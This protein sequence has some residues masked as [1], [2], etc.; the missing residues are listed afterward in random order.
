M[1]PRRQVPESASIIPFII[2][3]MVVLPVP[4]APIRATRSPR[5]ISKLMSSNKWLLPKLFDR[6]E[7]VRT[8]LP[9]TTEGS[10]SIR[11]P[12]D[13]AKGLSITSILDRSFSRLSAR[14]M[15]FSRLNCFNLSITCCWCL[16]SR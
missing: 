6:W 5:L 11:M 12:E 2:F 16:I 9:L 15:D 14:F 10:K 3:R 13:S 4:L 7:T 1:A 8:S